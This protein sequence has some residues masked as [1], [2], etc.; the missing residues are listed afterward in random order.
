MLRFER[1][2]K[3]YKMYFENEAELLPLHDDARPVTARAPKYSGFEQNHI[4]S[5]P[6]INDTD[7]E[8]ACIMLVSTDAISRGL[9]ALKLS[10]FGYN[11]FI[12]P[13]SYDEAV[14]MVDLN[15]PDI[16]LF[17]TRLTGCEPAKQFLQ[18]I[19]SVKH[20]AVTPFIVITNN[21]ERTLVND[22]RSMGVDECIQEMD[23]DLTLTQVV[24]S[25]VNRYFMWKRM[26]YESERD[27]LT[28]LINRRRLF[29]FMEYD[30]MRRKNNGMC[31]LYIDIDNFKEVNDTHGHASG[32]R[33]IRDIA[34]VISA[35]LRPCDKLTRMGGD[36]F[37]AYLPDT[38]QKSGVMAAERIRES[39]EDFVLS[40]FDST[41][42]VTA[43]IGVASL[44]DNEIYIRDLLH[45]QP[46][47]DLFQTITSSRSNE[48]SR[49]RKKIVEELIQMADTALYYGKR[50]ICNNCFGK[51]M[52][53]SGKTASECRGCGSKD[54]KHGKNQVA[55]FEKKMNQIFTT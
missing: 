46:L 31:V 6:R 54:L 7:P 36:E 12:Q 3:E 32:D 39:V 25:H 2:R 16:I 50:T 44:L 27:Y 9:Y 11:N 45:I 38:D 55:S 18:H 48:N 30:I 34:F 1:S 22:L 17:D 10:R 35:N 47:D 5:I 19:R 4:D 40:S 24:N 28:G 14:I 29:S 21:L 26:I 49:L 52:R 51:E 53:Q 43:T 15:K 20:M 33:L 42:E 41:V 13:S 8:N 37:L 23:I